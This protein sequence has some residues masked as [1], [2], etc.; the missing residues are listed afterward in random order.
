MTP[1]PTGVTK[2]P[3]DVLEEQLVVLFRRARAG[4]ER[5]A[6]ALHPELDAAAYGLLHLIDSAPAPTVTDLATRLSVGKPT[7]S[8]QISALEQLGLLTREQ[9]DAGRRT[10]LLK[11]TPD[12]RARLQNARDRRRQQLQFLLA[13][14]PTSDVETLIRLLARYNQLS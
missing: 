8:R 6:R 3:V 10:T 5:H 9:P 12:G 1:M 13:D 4:F 2:A 11:L 7:V 14:W